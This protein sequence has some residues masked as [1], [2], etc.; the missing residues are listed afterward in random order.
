M[1]VAVVDSHGELMAFTRHDGVGLP[2]I[3]LAQNKTYT[4]ARERQ[5][6]GNLGQWARD[7]GKDMGYWNDARVTGFKGGLPIFVDEQCVG[8][9]GVSGLSE[10]ED[11]AL[12]SQAIDVQRLQ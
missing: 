3:H 1:A 4:A 5:P 10:E 6:S 7:T 8:A 9:I 12:A 11:E 2:S